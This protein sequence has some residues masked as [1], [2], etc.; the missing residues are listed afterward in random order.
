MTIPP[1]PPATVGLAPTSAFEVNQQIGLH[2]KNFNDVK[3]A[4]NQ[5]RGWL[6]SVDLKVEPYFFSSDQETLLKTAV[7]QLDDALDGIDMQW[8]NRLLGLNG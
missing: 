2:L 1:S 4:I 5:D 3:N 7:L 6:A 8:I